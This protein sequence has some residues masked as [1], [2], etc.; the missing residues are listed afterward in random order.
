MKNFATMIGAAAL[1]LAAGISTPAAMNAAPA[2][3][4]K[5]APATAKAVPPAAPVVPEPAEKCVAFVA[6]VLGRELAPAE[7]ASDAALWAALEAGDELLAD[8][9]RQDLKSPFGKA[10]F[11]DGEPWVALDA[12]LRSAKARGG[13]AAASPQGAKGV[14]GGA[15][16]TGSVRFCAEHLP[17]LAEYRAVCA[18][19]RA[20][21]IADVVRQTPRLVYARHF[22]MGGSHYAYTEAVTD[23]QSERYIRVGA[24]L[25]LAEFDAAGGLWRETVLLDSPEGVIR[26]VDVDFDARRILFSWRKSNR[27]DDYHLYEMPVSADGVPQPAALRQLTSEPRVADYE[28]C[29]LP[30]GSIL[31][32]STRCQ[33]IVDCWWTE[34]SNLYRCDADGGNILRVSFDQVHDNYPTVSWDNRVLYTRWEY[35]DR[36]QMYPQPLFSMAPDGTNQTA[37]YGENSWF[38]TTIAHARAVPNSSAIFAVATGHHSAQPGELILIEPKRGRQ[39]TSGVTRVAPVRPHVKPDPIIID[40]YGQGAELFAYPWPLDER[41]LLVSHNPTGWRGI[42]SQGNPGT[43]AHAPFGIYWF[44]VAGERELLVSRTGGVGIGCGRPVP[45]APRRRPPARPSFVDYAKDH[46][47]FNIV[48][49]YQGAAMRG[50]ERGTVKTLRVIGLDFR[51]AGIGSNR[52]GGRGGHAMVCTPVACNNGAWDVKIPLGDVPVHPDGSVFFKAPARRPFYFQLLDERGRVV[53]TMRSWTVLQPGEDA[54]CVGCHESKDSAPPPSVRPP[55]AMQSAPA[56]LANFWR[57]VGRPEVAAGAAADPRTTKRGIS[58]P[59]DIQPILDKHCVGCHGGGVGSGEQGAGSGEIV[60]GK[61]GQR[62][63]GKG[64]RVVTGDVGEAQRSQSAAA[65]AAPVAS[66][67]AR[68]AATGLSPRSTDNPAPDLRAVPAPDG[69]SKRVWLRSYLN[70]VHNGNAGH[71]VLNWISAASEPT[72]LAPRNAGAA[73]SKLFALLDANHGKTRITREEIALLAAW[74]DMGVPFCG[75]YTEAAAW[76]ERDR[77]KHDHY[78]RKRT[79]ADAADAATLARLRAA[80]WSAGYQDGPPVVRR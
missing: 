17:S 73:R 6:E 18:K 54:S 78:Q 47:T 42:K 45:L 31:F 52:N 71:P 41:Q 68:G 34:V 39:E 25:C 30:D 55:K 59:Q 46:G 36:S 49:V 23:A 32:N 8:W 7:R 67:P 48:D 9:L 80:S 56:T 50:V 35:N 72:I 62:D 29:Y 57:A 19:R 21:R 44:N 1:A 40:Q 37:V 77:A 14:T 66:S 64:Q 27:G 65:P 60:R 43:G 38:P 20:A 53:Q 70:L 11:A 74:V 79:A 5:A 3:K 24:R 61:E 12:A 76:S 13:S 75:D 28:G 69:G 33:Q 4:A 2:A 51:V 15:T 26:D 63:K 58:F 10:L 22:V 16:T